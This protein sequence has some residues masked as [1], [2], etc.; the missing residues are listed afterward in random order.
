MNNFGSATLQK[1][2]S[3]M[4]CRTQKYTRQDG[5]SRGEDDEAGGRDGRHSS[6]RGG[7][8]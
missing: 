4:N 6:P 2:E 7:P 1:S 5:D 8:G 3:Y